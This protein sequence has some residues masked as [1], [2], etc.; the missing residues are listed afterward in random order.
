MQPQLDPYSPGTLLL[1]FRHWPPTGADRFPYVPVCKVERVCPIYYI[2]TGGGVPYRVKIA[3]LNRHSIALPGGVPWHFPSTF[4]ALSLVARVASLPV[5]WCVDELGKPFPRGVEYFK[6]E[7]TGQTYTFPK[8][9]ALEAC[10][11]ALREIRPKEPVRW[12]WFNTVVELVRGLKER[13]AGVER[14]SRDSHPGLPALVVTS[15]R[16]DCEHSVSLA[17]FPPEV[18]SAAPR[19]A[20][21]PFFAEVTLWTLRCGLVLPKDS[22]V[23]DEL[24]DLPGATTKLAFDAMLYSASNLY[25]TND[26]LHWWRKLS[27][28]L[29][30]EFERLSRTVG[31]GRPRLH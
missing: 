16:D 8:E 29:K 12:F 4:S 21:M 31:S 5:L 14:E 13:V 19:I 27:D 1:D 18:Q 17:P 6:D 30:C 24:A 22:S 10:G 23:L 20:P 7:F 2:L 9:C 26:G 15:R 11:Y 28:A 3:N 25:F